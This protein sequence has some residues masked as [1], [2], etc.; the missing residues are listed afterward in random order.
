M[1]GDS[2]ADDVKRAKK[3]EQERLQI[4]KD[5]KRY[6]FHYSRYKQHQVNSFLSSF[7]FFEM[8][9]H[10]TTSQ[11]KIKIHVTLLISFVCVC[12]AFDFSYVGY[13]LT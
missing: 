2:D 6:E 13:V 9:S 5:N 12:N 10:Y 3:E 7:F 4:A 8:I 11:K 1:K